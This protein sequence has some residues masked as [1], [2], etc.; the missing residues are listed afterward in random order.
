MANISMAT[1]YFIMY[2][3]LSFQCERS[4]CTLTQKRRRMDNLTAQINM[5]TS[6]DVAKDQ[7]IYLEEPVPHVTKRTSYRGRQPTRLACAMLPISASTS[8]SGLSRKKPGS[9]SHSGNDKSKRVA[10][11]LFQRI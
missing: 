11:F 4:G 1:K 8:G 2:S 9:G 6:T 3:L 10:D 5:S 7:S